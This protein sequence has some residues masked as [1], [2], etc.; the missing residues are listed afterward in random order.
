MICL[1]VRMNGIVGYC[2][3]RMV[4][5]FSKPPRRRKPGHA[6]AEGGK[7]AQP[8]MFLSSSRRSREANS[9]KQSSRLR[10]ATRRLGVG[11]QEGI[12]PSALPRAQSTRVGIQLIFA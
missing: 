11:N 10:L 2:P 6:E 5:N 3:S 12:G 8:E 7:P 4:M 1:A 9:G